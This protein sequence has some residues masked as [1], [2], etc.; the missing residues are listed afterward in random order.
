[1]VFAFIAVW[2]LEHPRRYE[3]TLKQA[4]AYI[5]EVKKKGTDPYADMNDNTIALAAL[6]ASDEVRFKEE[7]ILTEQA[8]CGCVYVVLAV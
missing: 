8:R 1:M 4:L 7:Q 3:L 2:L 5:R 6:A